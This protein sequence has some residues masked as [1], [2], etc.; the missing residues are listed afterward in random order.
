MRKNQIL[1]LF[2]CL[3]YFILSCSDDN[4]AG[5]DSTTLLPSKQG[6]YWIYINYTLD[7]NWNRN[8]DNPTIDSTII[9]GNITIHDTTGIVALSY[10]SDSSGITNGDSTYY[11][12]EKLKVFTYSNYFSNLLGN[13]PINLNIQINEQWV[14]LV[15][16]DDEDWKVIEQEIPETIIFPGLTMKGNVTILGSKSGTETIQAE[17]QNYNT[18]KFTLKMTFTGSVTFLSNTFPLNFERKTYLYFADNIGL[19]KSVIEPMKLSILQLQNLNLDGEE[20]ILIRHH[21]AN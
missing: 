3:S 15:D 7:S 16:G 17:S 14:K 6:T 5:S 2:I 11:Y 19:I 8:T 21:I 9:A 13:L 12:T 18:R 1:F 10:S 20:R 4:P